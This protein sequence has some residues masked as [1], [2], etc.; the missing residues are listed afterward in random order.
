MTKRCFLTPGVHEPGCRLYE[1]TDEEI[2][3]MPEMICENC[4]NEEALAPY[5]WCTVCMEAHPDEVPP[6]RTNTRQADVTASPARPARVTR[7]FGG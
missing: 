2:E 1:P 3:A 6:P 4:G 7:Y 5:R